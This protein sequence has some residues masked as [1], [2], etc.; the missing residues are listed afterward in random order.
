MHLKEN[1]NMKWIRLLLAGWSTLVTALFLASS[2]GDVTVQLFGSSKHAQYLVKGLVMS[3][4]VVPIIL[5]LYPHVYRMTGVR[6][7]TPVYSWKRLYHFIT[8]VLLAIALASLGFII[9]SFQGWVVIENW[10]TPDQWFVAL[11]INI[12]FA[13][14][15][16][17]LPEEFGLRG[18]LYDVLRHR[19]SAWLSVLFQTLLFVSVTI[20]VAQ[21]QALVGLA[22]GVSIDISYIVLILCFGVCLQLLRLWTGSLWASIGFHLAYLEIMRFAIFPHGYGVP[23]II[24]FH[25][26]VPGLAWLISASMIIVGGIIASLVILGTKR[27]IRKST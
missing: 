12:L 1:Q 16:E 21:I 4:L 3:G 9:A 14:F 8:G 23:P 25:E 24:T 5:Y 10:H 18:M 17:A 7:K 6:P 19:F 26:S 22:P 27:F 20:A 2:S 13:I 11:L 15:Y